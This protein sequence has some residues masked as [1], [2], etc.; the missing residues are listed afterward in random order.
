MTLM[1]WGRG[2][3]IW[4]LVAALLSIA[5]V[6]LLGIAPSAL[7]EGFLGTLAIMLSLSVTPLAVVIASVGAILLLVAVLRRDRF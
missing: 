7:S 4:G 2:L 1:K 5:P 6:L 3:L